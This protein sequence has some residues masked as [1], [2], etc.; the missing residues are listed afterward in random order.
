MSN[1]S[2]VDIDE[3]LDFEWSTIFI[4]EKLFKN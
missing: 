4:K 1:L 2:S 3:K